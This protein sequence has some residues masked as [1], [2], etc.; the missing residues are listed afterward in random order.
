MWEEIEFNPER[1]PLFKL[2]LHLSQVVLSFVCWCLEIAVFRADGAA[3]NG[4]NGWT[5][6]VC[7]LSIPAWI[8]LIMTPRF[9]RTRKFAQPHAMVVIDALFTVLWLSAFA[10]QAAYNTANSCGTA[11]A[12][13]KTIVAFGFFVFLLFAGTT[14]LSIYSLKYYEWNNRLPGY[15]RGSAEVQNIDPDKAAFSMAPH[16]EEAY[17]PVSGQ[18]HEEHDTSYGGAGL[19]PY[20]GPSGSQ[21]SDPYATVH[22]TNSQAS[23]GANSQAS[24]GANNQENP[25]RQDNPF[26]GE[27]EYHGS[28]YGSQV[29]GY[30]QPTAQDDYDDHRP[31]QFPAAN[32]DRTVR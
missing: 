9:P 1:V 14:F 31:A 13:S 8:Y 23:Y 29:G 5:F 32:Y 3:V 12:L 2:I 11:C 20:A 18:D 22:S 6:A 25:F 15:D 26:D 17:A 4:N 21:V 27:P 30:A 28:H 19:D 7:F 16:D 24:Y 10:T